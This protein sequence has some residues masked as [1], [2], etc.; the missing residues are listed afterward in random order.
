[1]PDISVIAASLASAAMAS[2][3][4]F[5]I[6]RARYARR[7]EDMGRRLE[8]VEA[9]RHLIDE[10]AQQA[11]RQIEQLQK[12]LAAARS[13][14]LTQTPT[15]AKVQEL[16]QMLRDGDRARELETAGGS[17]R[18]QLPLNGFADTLPMCVHP[19]RN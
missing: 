9:A 14:S 19:K 13:V 12:D 4:T 7:V 2:G 16:E 5:A 17:G 15:A 6:C 3:V 10:R 18:P 1:M 11:R 8:V